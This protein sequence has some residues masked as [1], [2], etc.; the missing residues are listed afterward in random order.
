[1]KRLIIL[2]LA[3]A[4]CALAGNL[5][6]SSMDAAEPQETTGLSVQQWRV[7][8]PPPWDATAA[9]LERKGDELRM[10]KAFSDALDYYRAAIEKTPK[11][12]RSQLYN[13]AGI[14]QLH[15]SRLDDAQRDFVNAVKRDK[16]NSEAINNLGVTYYLKKKYKKAIQS[17]HKALELKPDSA[18]YHGNLGRAYFSNKQYDL[19]AQEYARA[20]DLDPE[21]FSRHSLGGIT[22][23]MPQ[24]KGLFSFVL[25]KIYAQRGNTEES[26]LWLKRAVLEG[27]KDIAKAYQEKEFAVIREDPRFAELMA[28]RNQQVP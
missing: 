24:E 7:A 17:Y 12:E 2:L 11:K 13:K 4:P 28:M 21:I 15:L 9:E 6:S 22:A 23:R 26:L 1:M 14:A 16:R 5:P 18:S 20:L 27:Y 19:A 3:L 25:A 10:Q 8:P